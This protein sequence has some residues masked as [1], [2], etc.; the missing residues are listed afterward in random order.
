MKHTDFEKICSIVIKIL[1]EEN[2][3]ITFS[4][5]S[6]EAKKRENKITNKILIDVLNF[7]PYIKKTQEKSE[8]LYQIEFFKLSSLKEY[9]YRILYEKNK[10]MHYSEIWKEIQN[11]LSLS[12]L[13]ARESYRSLIGQMISEDRLVPIGKSGTWGLVE[14]NHET[15]TIIEII[16]KYLHQSNKPSSI[17]E[18]IDHISKKRPQIKPQSI[19]AIISQHKDKVLKLPNNLLILKEWSN[20]YRAELESK[21]TKDKIPMYDFCKITKKLFDKNNNHELTIKEMKQEIE[22]YNINWTESYCYIKLSQCPSLKSEKKKNTLYY[23]YNFEYKQKQKKNIGKLE[24]LKNK[25][26]NLFLEENK[27][28]I[29]L[30]LIISEITKQGEKKHNIYSVIS[31]NSDIFKKIN[32]GRNT[33]VEYQKKQPNHST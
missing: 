11:R 33:I 18:I 1:R 13:N 25:I 29:P 16:I 24:T 19:I 6:L 32:N 3:P 8:Q 7:L 4:K 9:A 12:D 14:W 30:R 10:V 20:Q 31:K 28:K 21:N 23:T 26:I 5:L 22:K 27:E 15:S 2:K 17:S